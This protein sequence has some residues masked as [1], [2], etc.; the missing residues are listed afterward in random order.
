MGMGLLSPRIKRSEYEAQHSL[1]SSAE[2][3]N[4][5]SYTSTPP[6]VFTIDILKERVNLASYIYHFL[7]N[8]CYGYTK[9]RLV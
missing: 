6:Y 1:P 2:V 9:T 4:A 7:Q 5:W 3:T 8:G